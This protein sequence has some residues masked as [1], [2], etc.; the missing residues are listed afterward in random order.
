MQ[1]P[2]DVAPLGVK[3][4]YCNC[5]G[6]IAINCEFIY[7][8]RGNMCKKW[9]P[10]TVDQLEQE[11]K[12]ISIP[13]HLIS[14]ASAREETDKD[15]DSVCTESMCCRSD[16][17]ASNEVLIKASLAKVDYDAYHPTSQIEM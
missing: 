14:E 13:R 10:E 5:I 12:R 7:Q 8:I 3:C 1:Q 16:E 6:H 15:R 4:Y 2:K 9:T 11:Q 17:S